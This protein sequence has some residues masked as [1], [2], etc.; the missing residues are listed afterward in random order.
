LKSWGYHL[1][2]DAAGL[3]PEK[4]RSKVYCENFL[5]ELC[6]HIKMTPFG[7]PIVVNFGEDPKVSG[8]TLIQLIQESNIAAHLVEQNNTGY[9]RQLN[10]YP[11]SLK[12]VWVYA[13]ATEN[14]IK[15]CGF[16]K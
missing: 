12:K 8:F 15:P 4:I 7:A 10:N 2:I 16:N 1:R 13:V 6:A 9:F 5:T 3:N 11:F 14:E